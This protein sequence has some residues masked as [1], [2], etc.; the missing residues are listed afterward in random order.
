MATVLRGRCSSLLQAAKGISLQVGGA[1]AFATASADEHVYAHLGSTVVT[2][3]QAA[4]AAAASAFTLTVAV[5]SMS[6]KHAWDRGSVD[7][8]GD[9]NPL[10]KASENL[11]QPLAGQAVRAQEAVSLAAPAVSATGVQPLVSRGRSFRLGS[12]IVPAA[13]RQATAQQ[14]ECK[15]VEQKSGGRTCCY[16]EPGCA[17][18]CVFIH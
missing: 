8:E 1:R 5:Y 12:P 11:D 3:A 4:A 14:P 7:N 16:S 13:G 17:A 6:Q 15:C 18:V 2:K 10:N 9:P